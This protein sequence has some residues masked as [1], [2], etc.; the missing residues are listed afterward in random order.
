[1]TRTAAESHC[2]VSV[3]RRPERPTT[4]GGRPGLLPARLLR[5]RGEGPIGVRR[6]ISMAHVAVPV[7]GQRIRLRGDAFDD[8]VEYGLRVTDPEVLGAL[9]A[10]HL[11]LRDRVEPLPRLVRPQV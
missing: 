4:R 2:P 10:D 9:D 8:L 7:A 5:E 3:T 6:R 1:M 11:R